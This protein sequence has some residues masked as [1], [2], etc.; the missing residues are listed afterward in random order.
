[1]VGYQGILQAD[2]YVGFNELVW[3]THKRGLFSKPAL[4]MHAG[5]RVGYCHRD[6]IAMA[7]ELAARRHEFQQAPNTSRVAAPDIGSV[8]QHS[9]TALD[10]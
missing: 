9:T 7:V 6:D 4:W 3:F 2:S 10:A 8:V 1:M 5:T